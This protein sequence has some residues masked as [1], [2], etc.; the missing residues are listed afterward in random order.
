MT[1]SS[2]DSLNALRWLTMP[3]AVVAAA[4]GSRRSCATG[5][6]NYVS[7]RP[8]MI[9]TSLAHMSRTYELAHE[10]RAFS[11]SL[12]RDDQSDVAVRAAIHCRNADKFEELSLDVQ[13]WSDVPALRDC[14]VVVWCSVQQEMTVGDYVVFIGRVEHA[15]VRAN[16]TAGPLVRFGGAYHEVGERLEIDETPYPL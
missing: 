8:A 12:L 6:L 11:V 13:S 2:E 1:E 10:S 16:G 9:S 14:G 15:I 4:S 3:V 7:L 5:T